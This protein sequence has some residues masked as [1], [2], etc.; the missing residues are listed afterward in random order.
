MK[1]LVDVVVE[2]LRDGCEGDL[3]TTIA[4]KYLEKD[5]NQVTKEERREIKDKVFPLLYGSVGKATL[6][7]IRNN[8]TVFRSNANGQIQ[9]G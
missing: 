4:A 6:H 9:Q 1:N 5:V 7:K 8:N 2:T 3:H